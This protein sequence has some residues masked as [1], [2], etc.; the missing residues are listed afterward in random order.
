MSFLYRT[1]NGEPI[2]ADAV[3]TRKAPAAGKVGKAPFRFTLEAVTAGWQRWNVTAEQV[4]AYRAESD[5]D[6]RAALVA[7]FGDAVEGASP[8]A[9]RADIFGLM[10]A[11]YGSPEALAVDLAAGTLILPTASRGKSASVRKPQA[12]RTAD[13]LAAMF[14]VAD[15]A[16]PTPEPSADDKPSDKSSG[17]K[18]G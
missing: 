5:A 9:P 12:E 11:D 13:A 14:A 4:A 10:L 16:E 6:K 7:S 3:T 18:A 15:A 2:H 17:G 1:V 8:I